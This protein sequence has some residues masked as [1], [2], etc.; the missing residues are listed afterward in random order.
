MFC[1]RSKGIV[2]IPQCAVQSFPM[3]YA[4]SLLG[5]NTLGVMLWKKSVSGAARC[6]WEVLV[7]RVQDKSAAFTIA[8]LDKVMES[9]NADGECEGVDK[10]QILSDTGTH[11]RS[12]AV[13]GTL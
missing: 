12:Y 7:S 10:V 3:Y 13:L 11:Y 8:L 6:W 5:L 4:G 1:P 2:R 9:A